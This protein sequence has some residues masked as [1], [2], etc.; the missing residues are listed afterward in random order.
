ML[1]VLLKHCT[2]FENMG[3]EMLLLLQEEHKRYLKPDS[4]IYKLIF[5]DNGCFI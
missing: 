2:Y 4:L 5:V 1:K 3:L